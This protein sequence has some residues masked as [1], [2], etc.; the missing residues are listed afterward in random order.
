MNI[1]KILLRH[2]FNEA[3]RSR[4]FAGN[5]A[6]NIFIGLLYSMLVLQF[7]AVGLF[8]DELLKELLPDANHILLVNGFLIIYSIFDLKMR[9]FLQKIHGITVIPYLHLPIKK[10]TL[11]HYLISRSFLS[12]FNYFPLLVIIPLGIKLISVEYGTLSGFLWIVNYFLILQAISLFN[13]FINRISYRDTKIGLTY[14]FILLSVV[15]IY[16]YKLFNLENLSFA[17]FGSVLENN[18]VILIPTIVVIL[19][20]LLNSRFMCAHLYIED[21]NYVKEI[22]IDTAS[23]K[24]LDS[25]G[26]IGQYLSLELKLLFRNKRPRSTIYFSAFFLLFGFLAY[27]V[28]SYREQELFYIYFG[29]MLTGMLLITYGQF[30]MCWESG[31]YDFIISSRIK[32]REYLKAKY[33]ILIF[34]STVCFILVLPFALYDIT[35]VYRNTALYLYNIGVNTVVMFF[36]SSYSRKSVDLDVSV[37]NQQGKG[38]SQYLTVVPTMILPIFVYLPVSH[39]FGTIAGYVAL[40]MMGILGLLFSP[41]LLNIITNQM[42]GQK[43]KMAEAFRLRS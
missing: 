31:Y 15:A 16:Y 22:S 28:E 27:G 36:L 23:I 26:N 21:L 2:Q 38:A 14:I 37:M 19:L 41:F 42:N 32:F 33:Y 6:I 17:I 5:M 40:G 10:N 35:I 13:I 1:I 24:G 29:M 20:Y 25:F 18:L 34:G 8:I 39:F 43:Y 4:N 7:L 30:L 12:L 3:V 11:V 9:Y